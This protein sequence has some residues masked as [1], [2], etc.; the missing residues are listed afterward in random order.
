MVVLDEFAPNVS[1]NGYII[2]NVHWGASSAQAHSWNQHLYPKAKVTSIVVK[3]YKVGNPTGYLKCRIAS[4]VGIYGTS[5]KPDE[6]LETSTNSKNIAT[7]SSIS[8]KPTTVTFTFVGS[9]EISKD[10]PYTFYVYA[11]SGSLDGSNYAVVIGDVSHDGNR[12]YPSGV[13]GTWISS[14]NDVTFTVNGEEIVTAKPKKFIGDGLVG[15]VM[16]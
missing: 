14:S 10:T 15:F 9:A 4:H 5:S 7:L 16:E 11:D 6:D 13:E 12:A 1:G 3:A 8:A 2:Y